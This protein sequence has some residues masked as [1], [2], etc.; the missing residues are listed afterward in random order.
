M[1]TARTFDEIKPLVELCKAGRF[2]DV[3]KWLESG[4]PVNLPAQPEI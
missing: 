4:K 2:Y 3:E 1:K